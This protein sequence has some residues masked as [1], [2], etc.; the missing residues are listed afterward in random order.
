MLGRQLLKT[1]CC[2]MVNA[3]RIP[4]IDQVM[5]SEPSF[6]FA[7]AF[8]AHYFAHYRTV[9]FHILWHVLCC[10]ERISPAVFIFQSR[11]APQILSTI[12]FNAFAARKFANTAPALSLA[13]VFHI[14]SN[15]CI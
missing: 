4:F 9:S 1:V 5:K 2:W 12:G 11:K 10:L 3:A 7:E 15:S 8:E 13:G 14:W 6:C